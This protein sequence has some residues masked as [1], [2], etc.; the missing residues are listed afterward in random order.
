MA[1]ALKYYSSVVMKTLISPAEYLC[2]VGA[3]NGSE[4]RFRMSYL[5]L[6]LQMAL[7]SEIEC[8]CL[9]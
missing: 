1:K 3:T 6:S 8:G 9:G 2:G 4:R 7:P 5:A